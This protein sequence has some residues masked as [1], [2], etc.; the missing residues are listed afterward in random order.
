MNC[1]KSESWELFG[2]FQHSM[3]NLLS[4]THQ[5]IVRFKQEITKLYCNP[6]ATG[7][8]EAPVCNTQVS[9]FHS[10][11]QSFMMYSQGSVMSLSM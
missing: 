3:M 2:G 10:G 7:G 11:V 4:N 8:T 1:R 9:G 5:F 6:A